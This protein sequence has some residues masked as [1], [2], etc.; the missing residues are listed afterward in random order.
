MKAALRA[1]DAILLP[2]DFDS[3]RKYSRLF[4][5]AVAE[6]APVIEDR[7]IDEIYIDLT[8]VPGVRDAVGHDPL[9]GVKAVA[10]EIKNSVGRATGLTCSIGVTPNKLLSKIASELDKP[11]GISVLTLDDIPARVWPLG[12]RKINGIGPKASEKLIKLGIETVGD[13]AAAD[14]R[15]LIE[16]FGDSYG[17]WLHNASHGRDSRPVVTHSEPVSISRET[18]FERDLS[19]VHD[20]L[21][22]GQIMDELCESLSRDLA[23]KR[24]AGKTVGIKLRFEGFVTVTRD[25]TVKLPI[26]SA[27]DIRRAVGLCLK[28]VRFDKRLRLM[29]V[30]IGNLVHASEVQ[31][32]PAAARAEPQ[33]A[34]DNLSLF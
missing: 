12:V 7:G 10:R 16:Q 34:P 29:G 15:W 3:Y 31:A 17:H 14:P 6:V 2:A 22:L 28:R 4:K 25:Q 33:P 18:T 19:A 5:A 20:R 24:Y 1:P 27:A 21:L 8:D 26:S 23:R 30:R 32:A 11:D 13:I 9:G